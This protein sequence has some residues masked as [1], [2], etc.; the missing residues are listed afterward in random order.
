MAKN[1]MASERQDTRRNSKGQVIGTPKMDF[2]TGHT[3]QD[4]FQYYKAWT[5]EAKDAWTSEAK[6]RTALDSDSML[7]HKHRQR[8]RHRQTEFLISA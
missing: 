4:T 7:G 3:T 6:D 1:I 8:P 5:S 2:S